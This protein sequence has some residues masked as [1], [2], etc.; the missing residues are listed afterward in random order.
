MMQVIDLPFRNDPGTEVLPLGAAPDPADPRWSEWSVRRTALV[1]QLKRDPY[2]VVAPAD[3]GFVARLRRAPMALARATFLLDL[4]PSGFPRG[5]IF[6]YREHKLGMVVRMA[7]RWR[8]VGVVRCPDGRWGVARLPTLIAQP[9]DGGT[10]LEFDERAAVLVRRREGTSC[11]GRYEPVGP[12]MPQRWPI[13]VA[14]PVV[15][16]P[17]DVNGAAVMEE[18]ARDVDSLEDVAR[19]LDLAWRVFQRGRG[20]ESVDAAGRRVVRLAMARADAGDTSFARAAGAVAE[21]FA[22]MVEAQEAQRWEVRGVRGLPLLVTAALS[23]RV[24]SVAELCCLAEILF[25]SRVI[26]G[27]S[28]FVPNCRV[29][30]RDA[31][32]LEGEAVW[33]ERWGVNLRALTGRL[34]LPL[35][36][37]LGGIG[38]TLVDN[39][40]QTLLANWWRKSRVASSVAMGEW[41]LPVAAGDE[42]IT[43]AQQQRLR[44]LVRADTQS[45][46]P[47]PS[48]WEDPRVLLQPVT[49]G[50]SEMGA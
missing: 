20:V 48:W 4:G 1:V 40:L 41:F 28:G 27:V 23:R 35:V 39:Y 5:A 11:R 38:G 33:E 18:A 37:S 50:I 30:C 24:F 14:V 22:I 15:E 19:F 7:Q 36:A 29:A 34:D 49:P 26:C 42:G 13:N 10:V 25:A 16:V 46:R 3:R 6:H 2:T 44:E 32:D 47:G 9:V 43:A 17:S 12:A 31:A 45:F 21:A 8:T